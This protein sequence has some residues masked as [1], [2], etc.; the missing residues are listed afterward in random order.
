MF[1]KCFLPWHCLIPVPA[2]VALRQLSQA[3]SRNSSSLNSAFISFFGVIFS[4]MAVTF[5]LPLPQYLL[6]SFSKNMHVKEPASLSAA[7]TAEH[8]LV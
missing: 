7:K 4:K 3:A 6:G 8:V 1:T 5:G 2:T